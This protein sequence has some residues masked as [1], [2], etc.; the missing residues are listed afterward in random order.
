MLGE[1]TI[2]PF[3]VNHGTKAPGALGFV[4]QHN[5][6]K[7]VVT[8]DFLRVPD[9][10]DPLLFDADVMFLDA[11]TWHPA[12]HTW[13][14]SVLG[15]LRLI[16]HWR[17]RRAY[18]THYSG[19]EDRDDAGDPIHGPLSQEQFRRELDRVKGTRDI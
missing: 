7:I 2:T 4:V 5:A 10:D 18:M 6:R 3:A 1:L 11:N 12:E 9:E 17:P 16:E 8:G 13:H 14:Q 19:Y 15:N